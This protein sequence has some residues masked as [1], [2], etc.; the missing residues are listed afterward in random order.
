MEA[1]NVLLQETFPSIGGFEN[2]L[3]QQAPHQRSRLLP[4]SANIFHMGKSEHFI[5]TVYSGTNSIDYMDSLYPGTKPKVAVIK[6]IKEA[7]ILE[8]GKFVVKSVFVQ[9]QTGVDCGAF[10]VANLWCVLKGI[11]PRSIR[12]RESTIRSDL[13]K[14]FKVRKLD[15]HHR[16]CNPRQAAKSY[17]FN[18]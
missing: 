4:V 9:K 2:I 7:Y 13:Y 17:S 14:S 5:A 6:Q 3:F 16:Q 12:I 18:F 8:P 1:A 11:D 10:S 15:F